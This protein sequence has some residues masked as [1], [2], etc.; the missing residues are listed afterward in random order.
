MSSKTSTKPLSIK[1]TDNTQT[2][3]DFALSPTEPGKFDFYR[4]HVSNQIN[5]DNSMF[6]D[7]YEVPHTTD[8]IPK[9]WLPFAQMKRLADQPKTASSSALNSETSTDSGKASIINK[10]IQTVASFSS[11]SDA[12][13]NAMNKGHLST[14]N[15]L[16][17]PGSGATLSSKELNH[18]SPQSM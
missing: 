11:L 4:V 18:L 9:R 6:A 17:R 13:K 7:Q 3:Y 16:R 8:E 5:Q 15:Q 12:V 10:P 2:G 1:T 14:T